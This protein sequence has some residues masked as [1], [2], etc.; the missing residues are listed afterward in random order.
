MTISFVPKPDYFKSWNCRP[1]NSHFIHYMVQMFQSFSISKMVTFQVITKILFI[2]WFLVAKRLFQGIFEFF[3]VLFGLWGEGFV[4]FVFDE[5]VQFFISWTQY[6]LELPKIHLMIMWNKSTFTLWNTT[7][8]IY[9]SIC[10]C[11]YF[12]QSLF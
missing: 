6:L 9:L 12:I 2:H 4:F 5:V 7:S 8:E 3:R 1:A 10:F 11:F